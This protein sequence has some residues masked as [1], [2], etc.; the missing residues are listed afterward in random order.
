LRA[1]LQQ[2]FLLRLL[3][4]ARRT[5]PVASLQTASAS[6]CNSEA[7]LPGGSDL[8]TQAGLGLEV[9]ALEP[10]AEILT[11]ST[12]KDLSAP[13]AGSVSRLKLVHI[14]HRS[15]SCLFSTATLEKPA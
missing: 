8:G 4:A 3:R 10:A 11:F 14:S 2:S 9:L 7:F 5:F 13:A 1:H 15:H 12:G 6:S